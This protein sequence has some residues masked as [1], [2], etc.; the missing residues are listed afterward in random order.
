M[1]KQYY[2]SHD[3]LKIMGLSK[4]YLQ[5]VSETASD[6]IAMSLLIY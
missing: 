2:K 6:T 3:G 1:T 5:N 4:K